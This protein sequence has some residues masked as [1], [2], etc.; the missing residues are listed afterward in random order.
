MAVVD[1]GVWK[2]MQYVS[3]NAS[4]WTRCHVTQQAQATHAPETQHVWTVCM[5]CSMCTPVLLRV[6]CAG[7]G[8]Q[9]TIL[10]LCLLLQ[11]VAGGGNDIQQYRCTRPDCRREYTS[12]QVSWGAVPCLG[13]TK[14]WCW[15]VSADGSQY[16]C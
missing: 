6:P 16:A 3:S 12:L 14:R 15:Q 8:A 4:S 10:H 13:H 5:C 9:L 11:K 7:A 2:H 1:V